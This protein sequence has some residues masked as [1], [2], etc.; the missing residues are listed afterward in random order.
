MFGFEFVIGAV[1]AIA[2]LCAALALGVTFVAVFQVMVGKLTKTLRE[3]K[4]LAWVLFGRR[5]AFDYMR[6][7]REYY[8]D[9]E[10]VEMLED[11]GVRRAAPPKP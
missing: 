6:L 3:D 9:L 10:V 4:P 11:S 1:L 7:A 2:A 5:Q 8:G